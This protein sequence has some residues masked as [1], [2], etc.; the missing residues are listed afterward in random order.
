MY[1]AKS[2]LLAIVALTGLVAAQT[3]GCL[4]SV[5]GDQPNP[6]DLKT[7][8]GDAASK[9]QSAI[10]SE[11]GD[12]SANALQVF[13][14][15][16][17]SAGFHVAEVTSTASVVSSTGT[18]TSKPTGSTSATA[19]GSA[20]GSGATGSSSGS[21]SGSGSGASST[22]TSTGSSASASAFHGAAPSNQAGSAAA[23][24]AAVFVGF[25]SLLLSIFGSYQCQSGQRNRCCSDGAVG[26][27]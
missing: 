8:C 27:A 4:L 15:T 10:K 3:P 18:A 1:I 21:G 12:G 16:C 11:C 2:T 20:S 5:V 14:S 23:F 13:S 25:A 24:A 19:T 26:A 7:I 6:A 22:A 17:S 9:V